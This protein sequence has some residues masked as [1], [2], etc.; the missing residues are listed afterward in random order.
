MFTRVAARE[1]GQY[2]IR[3]N[4]VSPGLIW[5]EGI[6][7]S[8]RDGVKRWLK[9]VPQGTMGQAVDARMF[10]ASPAGDGGIMTYGAF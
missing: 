3:I 4:A 10:M 7:E 5:K 2:G 9:A 6:E 8:Y 1:L